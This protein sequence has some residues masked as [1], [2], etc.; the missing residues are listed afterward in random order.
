M[1][2]GSTSFLIGE[3]QHVDYLIEITKSGC[4]L[5]TSGFD[6]MSI[7]SPFILKI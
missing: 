5:M 4:E 1:Y 3:V 6:I 2:M 7:K